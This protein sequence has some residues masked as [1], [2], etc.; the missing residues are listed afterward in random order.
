VRGATL[1][2]LL[3]PVAAAAQSPPAPVVHYAAAARGA[4]EWVLSPAPMIDLAGPAPDD[5]F[6]EV[7]GVCL[8][9]DGRVAVAEATANQILLFD[10]EGRLLTRMG[11]TGRGPAEFPL[12]WRLL[13]TSGRLIGIGSDA[14]AEAFTADGRHRTSRA[15]PV[16]LGAAAA[17]RVGV[18]ADGRVVIVARRVPDAVSAQDSVAHV[19]VALEAADGASVMPIWEVP[20]ARLESTPAGRQ[21]TRNVRYAPFG[22]VAAAG[23]RIC[24]LYSTAW[25]LRCIDPTGRMALTVTRDVPRQPL[26][27]AARRF[28]GD[29]HRASNPNVP[30]AELTAEI[31]RFRFAS[32]APVAGRL[33][34]A[35]NGDV[36]ISDFD[37]RMGRS[38]PGPLGAPAR[39]VRWHVVDRAGRWLA[40]LTLPPRFHPYAFTRT[41]IAGVTY[42]EDD[43]PRV[44]VWGLG[45]RSAPAPRR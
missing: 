40:D 36:W 21:A 31:G 34:V 37:E 26:P 4:Q 41:R 23:D 1:A 30:A 11:R 28:A 8:L 13:C 29:A 7:H 24:T 15:R 2:V 17:D 27:E 32:T 45:P 38:G 39:A 25:S 35:D 12:L 33:H 14:R 44:T 18:L 5:P 6:G 22:Q 20:R 16:L 42:G 10:A 19:V 43:A 3:V 9:D